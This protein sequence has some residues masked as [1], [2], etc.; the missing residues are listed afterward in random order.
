MRKTLYLHI[1]HFKTGT[2]AIQVFLQDNRR[3]L[4][5]QNLWVAKTAL[6][7]CKHSALAFCLYKAAGVQTLMH[8]YNK[9]DTPQQQWAAL[10]DELRN[11]KKSRMIVSTEEF[12]RL[13]NFPK[14]VEQLK[15]VVA[16]AP[17]I[18]FKV[19]AYL[20]AP[21]YHLR[22][23]YNQLVK[24]GIPTPAFN[25]AAAG[26]IEPIHYDY[27]LALQPWIDLFG[28]DAV[29]L[30]H[31]AE[32]GRQSNRLLQDFLSIFEIREP[33][34]NLKFRSKDP[35]PRMDDDVIE[36]VRI[37]QN[38]G[39]PRHVIETAAERIKTYRDLE[40]TTDFSP[41]NDGFEV[42]RQQAVSGLEQLARQAP[43]F[44]ETLSQF[45]SSLPQ[46]DDATAAEGWHIVGLVL[47]ELQA[48]R[49]TTLRQ[50]KILAQRLDA[51][52]ALQTQEKL[53]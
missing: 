3:L 36:L 34:R 26:A 50:N 31:Y 38:T 48:L 14:A 37:L 32:G 19:I 6:K 52:E 8:G 20:R 10:F 51:L 16:M 25:A 29:T 43:G 46:P 5:K 42:M 1:G 2:T 17:D 30:R 35:N 18:D 39:A 21:E 22:S 11:S 49:K 53:R 44:S 41:A 47:N 9:P 12:M 23:W 28:A 7:H 40:Q 45:Q 4:E 13:G 24:M 15:Q 27:A 33:L